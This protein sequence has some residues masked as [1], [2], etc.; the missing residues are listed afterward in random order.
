MLCHGHARG[1]ALERPI[2][3]WVAGCRERPRLPSDTAGGRIGIIG[4]GNISR[5][6]ATKLTALPTSSSS[7]ART[8]TRAARRRSPAEFGVP[9]VLTP[10]ELVA[11][12]DV[13]VVVNLTVPA[14][15]SRSPDRPSRRASTRTP[16]SPWRSTSPRLD[17]RR[18]SRAERGLRLGCAP[19]TF[20]GAG[21]QTCR[22]LIDAGAIGTPLAANAF[23]QGSG[24]ESWHPDPRFFYQRGAGPLFDM[25]VYYVTALVAL[26]GPVARVTA[27][28]RTPGHVA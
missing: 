21:L 24:P 6:Y 2:T 27:S 5:A 17:P 26:L 10:D 23:F 14:R 1:V 20:L 28:A 16:R 13:D 7:P 22:A 19:D 3:S 9:S 15:T 8:S 11:H 25:G 4:C 12:P 18:T